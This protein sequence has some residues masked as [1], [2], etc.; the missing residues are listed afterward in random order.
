MKMKKVL[1]FPLKYKKYIYYFNV[2]F[3][4]KLFSIFNID[5]NTG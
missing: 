4:K 1:Y 3:N 2:Y 5:N